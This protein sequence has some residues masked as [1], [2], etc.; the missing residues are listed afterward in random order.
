MPLCP[1]ITYG[2]MDKVGTSSED[3]AFCQRAVSTVIFATSSANN[4]PLLCNRAAI[5]GHLLTFLVIWGPLGHCYFSSWEALHFLVFACNGLFFLRCVLKLLP[6]TF[7]YTCHLGL[8]HQMQKLPKMPSYRITRL[9]DSFKIQIKN[10]KRNQ[11]KF[12]PSSPLFFFSSEYLHNWGTWVGQYGIRFGCQD[13][14][15]KTRIFLKKLYFCS[16]PAMAI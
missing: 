6:C 2:N 8:I 11:L 7:H 15:I 13:S 9:E 10:L 12:V 5:V 3:V 4:L 14:Y 16:C 1:S